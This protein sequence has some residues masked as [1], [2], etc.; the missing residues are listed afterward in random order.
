MVEKEVLRVGRLFSGGSHLPFSVIFTILALLLVA[1]NLPRLLQNPGLLSIIAAIFGTVMFVASL[2]LKRK[3][4]LIAPLIG[5]AVTLVSAL[6]STTVSPVMSCA[7][8]V[9]QGYPYPWIIRPVLSLGSGCPLYLE[10][11]GS[12]LPFGF[13]PRTIFAYTGFIM[14]VVFYTLLTLAILELV[15]ATRLFQS[16]S[17]LEARSRKLM[18]IAIVIE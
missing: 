17:K 18:S 6:Y 8:Q 3:Q 15:P 2:S 10:P 7:T 1:F 11:I 4:W 14:D 13:V 12:A 9:S 16:I 5:I